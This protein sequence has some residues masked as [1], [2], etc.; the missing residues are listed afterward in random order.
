MVVA[1]SLEAYDTEERLLNVKPKHKRPEGLI[2][3]GFRR[4]G[5]LKD[6]GVWDRLRNGRRA[7]T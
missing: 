4:V 7:G 6:V 5:H 2:D 3:N 1:A